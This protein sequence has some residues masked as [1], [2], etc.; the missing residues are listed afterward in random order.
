MDQFGCPGHGHGH[1]QEAFDD[2]TSSLS[3]SVL[4][5]AATG[6]PEAG[7]RLLGRWP[8]L[9]LTP[10]CQFLFVR[11]SPFGFVS[12]VYRRG[13]RAFVSEMKLMCFE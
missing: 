7:V 2:V 3:T 6:E 13:Q 11:C 10:S 8:R 9:A 1:G 12:T 4:D 5:A